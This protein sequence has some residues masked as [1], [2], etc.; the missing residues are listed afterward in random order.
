MRTLRQRTA[1]TAVITT[2]ALAAGMVTGSAAIAA[3]SAANANIRTTT[4]T[5]VNDSFV[6]RDGARLTL[7]GETF[8][9][10]GANAYWLGLD[11]NVGGVD[12]PTAYRIKDAL[13]TAKELGLTVIRSHMMTSTSQSDTNPLA[14]MPSLGEYNDEAFKTVDFA[15]AYAGSI[16]LRFVLPLTDE[17]AYYHG[18]HRD[19]ITP[20]G[21]EPTDFYTN[22]DAVSAYQGYVSHILSRTNALTGVKYV[23]DPTI[24]AW[25]LG[26]E[27]EGMTPDWIAAQSDFIKAQAPQQLVAAGRRFDIDPDTLAATNLDIVDVHYYPPT[28]ARIAADAATITDAG[29]VYI[30][31]EWGSPAASP[32]LLDPLVSNPDVTGM[33][34][35]SLFPHNDRG[36]FVSHDD[37]FTLHYPGDT[38]AARAQTDAI[39]AYS[40]ALG[41]ATDTIPLAPP[42]ITEVTTTNGINS[43]AWRGS[44]GA[45]KYAIERSTDDKTWTTVATVP[46]EASPVLDQNG[47]ADV[48]YR[49]TATKPDGAAATSGEVAVPKGAEVLVD[50]L[51]S[52]LLT[53]AFENATIAATPTGG[54]AVATEAAASLTWRLAGADTASFLLAAGDPADVKVSSSPD[55]AT[56]TDATT[57]IDTS[58]GLTRVTAVDLAGDN[59]RITF[60][61][62]SEVRLARATLT[63]TANRAALIDP[64]NDFSLVSSKTGALSIDAG[65]PAQF[66]GDGGRAK[67]DSADPASLTWHYDDISSATFTAW[68]WPDQPVVPLVVSGSVD[69][70]TFNS[71]TPQITGGTGNWKRYDYTVSALTDVNYLRVSWEGAQGEPWTP[72][73]GQL[74]LF[75]PNAAE[76]AAPGDF[77]LTQ[78]TDNATGLTGT[79]ALTWVQSSDA[80]YYRVVVARDA[81]LT[82]VVEKSDTLTATSFTPSTALKPGTTYYWQVN[83]VNGYGET[84]STPQVAS[85]STA[86]LPTDTLTVDD[87]EGY[88]DDATLAAAYPRNTGGGPVTSTI[89]AN[90]DT[91]SKA[92][93]FSYDLTGPGYA[94]VVRT[95][96]APQ[97]WWGYNS[98]QFDA[99]ATPGQTLSV[100]FVTAGAYWE[101]NVPVTDGGWQTY[102]V[103]FTE[104]KNPPWAGGSTLDLSSVTQYAFYLGGSGAGT[105][106]VDN[107]RVVPT[108]AGPQAPVNTAAPSISG[109]PGVGQKLTAAPGQWDADDLA[110][111]YQWL[112]DGATITGA[113]TATYTV[114]KIDQGKSITAAVTATGEGGTTAAT[115]DA[116]TVAF[117]SSLS[118]SLSTPLAFSWSKVTATVQLTTMAPGLAGKTV[119]VRVGS[120]TVT[121]TLDAKGKATIVLPKQRS[122]IYTVSAEFAG[123][124]MIF[125]SKSKARV[126]VVL[127]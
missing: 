76:A 30:A 11:E 21:L 67:R 102:S 19:F 100:Q 10:N 9:F 60:G 47:A 127:F 97:S 70:E 92:G 51:E 96:A 118:L 69:G 14:I 72:Q 82:D 77:T 90:P 105:L 109:I 5:N 18:G 68:Y 58:E 81:A 108:G 66:G 42:L 125:N 116:V 75:S 12:F 115:S 38:E 103:D 120:K 89:V 59:V 84:E 34:F 17:W 91:A 79:P 7:D 57:S 54:V 22:P 35:W 13:D 122:G 98:V 114:A 119:A 33:M 104:F 25:E 61:A 41:Y 65:S 94:G 93:L 45:T 29:K 126:L 4:W 37:G 6:T 27:L 107:V 55:G 43:I 62:D 46:A 16:G 24:L 121:G 48:R 88:A 64:L 15:I 99:Q 20:L 110:F 80:A 3:P 63:G 78:P 28:A 40:R 95:L 101:A 86:P 26:N 52:L 2:I 73:I 87:F 31:G 32:E 44:A 53:S 71:L 106:L 8:R 56:W 112:R 85:F 111:A 23:D 1:V 124:P 50:P 49:V 36:G 117:T 123:D 74:T 83:A 113:T 39:K